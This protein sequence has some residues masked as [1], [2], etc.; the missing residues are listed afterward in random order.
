MD[1]VGV[2]FGFDVLAS[3]LALRGAGI[4]AAGFGH[5]VRDVLGLTGDADVQAAET[6]RMVDGAQPALV[7]AATAAPQRLL[8]HV[9]CRG[10]HVVLGVLLVHRV[11]HRLA[12]HLVQFSAVHVGPHAAGDLRHQDHHQE[13]EELPFTNNYVSNDPFHQHLD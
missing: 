12:Y 2:V 7:V 3:F 10:R 9:E 4:D 5:H 6:A 11:L 1:D 8:D 13:H